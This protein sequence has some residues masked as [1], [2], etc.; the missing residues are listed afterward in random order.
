[1]AILQA[2]DVGTEIVLDCGFTV[3]TATVM[4]IVARTPKGEKKTWSA[5]LEGTTKIKYTLATGD[6]NMAGTWQLQAYIEMPGWKGHGLPISLN[7]SNN[8]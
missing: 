7:V 8:L 1:M 4:Q 3:S 5:I 6:L 2:G